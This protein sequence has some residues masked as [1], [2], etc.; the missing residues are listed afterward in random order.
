MLDDW[1]NDRV[2]LFDNFKETLMHEE[3]V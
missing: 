3:F 2:D 1:V